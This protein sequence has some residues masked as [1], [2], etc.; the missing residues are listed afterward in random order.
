VNQLR[1]APFRDVEKTLQ[2][3]LSS[4]VQRLG[5]DTYASTCSSGFVDLSYPSRVGHV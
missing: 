5:W 4:A 3:I 2:K 1:A